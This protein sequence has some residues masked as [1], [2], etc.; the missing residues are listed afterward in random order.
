VRG[1][2][3]R[4]RSDPDQGEEARHPRT[5]DLV[6]APAR[7]RHLVATS[8]FVTRLL[9]T[10]KLA[11]QECTG[12]ENVSRPRNRREDAM[13]PI[14]LRDIPE[15]EQKEILR[16]SWQSV[17]GRWQFAAFSALGPEQG[18]AINKEIARAVHKGAMH[19]LLRAFNLSR[20]SNTEEFYGVMTAAMELFFAHSDFEYKFERVS[21]CTFRGAITKCRTNDNV[22]SAGVGDIYECGCFS[23]RDGWYEAMGVEVEEK[24][25]R[26]LLQGDAACEITFTVKSW[27]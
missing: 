3:F 25:E 6:G 15:E 21:D 18:N 16:K 12:R 10:K 22:R 23:C 8:P 9:V 17:D 11:L 27:K 1:A 2:R 14:S 13:T 26:R 24:C 7:R 20:V 19:K 4:R 5:D